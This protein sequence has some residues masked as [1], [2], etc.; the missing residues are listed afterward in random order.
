MARNDMYYPPY[1]NPMQRPISL[2][3]CSGA[4]GAT[5]MKL[6]P[7]STAAVFDDQT[8]RVYI[9]TNEG[10]FMG[11]S[12]IKYTFDLV[13]IPTPNDVITRSEFDELRR[14]IENVQHAIS[15]Q[16]K[17][18]GLAE[19]DEAGAEDGKQPEHSA[20]GSSNGRKRIT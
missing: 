15:E 16:L 5:E 7:E 14:S 20:T 12:R 19:S 8:D 18:T 11:K 6:P 9:V 1:Y 2:L 17:S 13:K 4:S 3:H 10:D